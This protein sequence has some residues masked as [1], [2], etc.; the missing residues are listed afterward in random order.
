MKTK[1]VFFAGNDTFKMHVLPLFEEAKLIE[2]QNISKSDI[3]YVTYGDHFSP[4]KYLRYWISKKTFVCHWIGSDVPIWKKKLSSQNPLI[5]LHYAYWR[6]MIR[7]KY[8][9]KQMISI[10]VAEHL[11]EG[12]KDIGI[13]AQLFP[14]TSINNE[15]IALSEKLKQPTRNI[16]FISYIPVD[17]FKFYGG[18]YFLECAEKLPGKK[19]LMIVKDSNKVEHSFKKMFPSNVHLLPEV[20]FDE[21]LK[22]LADSKILLRFTQH[23][24][25]SLMVLESLLA[26]MQVFWTRPFPQTCFV[27]LDA[28]SSQS[29]AERINKTA[30]N[31]TPNTAGRKYVIENLTVESMQKRFNQLFAVRQKN[32]HCR[33]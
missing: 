20:P 33:V 13:P 28:E 7:W 23:D 21:L 8:K 6:R 18:H 5:R 2:T 9:R 12:L 22:L 26:E 25:L 27:N 19:F 15:S 30:N 14:I 4:L 1:T 31:W 32:I 11:C 10:A 3:I 29:L 17:N 16:D 24:G